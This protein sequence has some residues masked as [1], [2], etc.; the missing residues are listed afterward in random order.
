VANTLADLAKREYRFGRDS[1]PAAF[2]HEF[3][4]IGVAL[5]RMGQMSGAGDVIYSGDDIVLT[6]LAAF[7]FRLFSPNAAVDE[8]P[9]I[10]SQQSG[11]PRGER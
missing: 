6:D 9:A 3:D 11:H 4:R 2:P 5:T 10:L 8:R 1:R 7:D